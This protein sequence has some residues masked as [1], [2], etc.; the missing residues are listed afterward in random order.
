M[1]ALRLAILAA[2]HVRQDRDVVISERGLRYENISVAED[3]LK[4]RASPSSVD[5]VVFLRIQKTGGTTFGEN[6][7]RQQCNK[8][9][10]ACAG[11][12]HLDYRSAISFR[13]KH[14][15]SRIVTFLRDPVERF[16]SEFA[17]LTKG[18][19]PMGQNQWDMWN[20][21]SNVT[22]ILHSEESIEQRIRGFLHLKGSATRNRQTLYLLGFDRQDCPH[23]QKNFGGHYC[24]GH[25]DQSAGATPGTQYDWDGE[26]EALSRRA[27]E[28]LAE[29]DY[30][31]TDCFVDSIAHLSQSLNWD[32]GTCGIEKLHKRNSGQKGPWRTTLSTELVSEIE[33]VNSA[34]MK[35]YNEAKKRFVQKNP[36]CLRTIQEHAAGTDNAFDV[37]DDLKEFIIN[38]MQKE[39]GPVPA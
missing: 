2:A 22:T 29:A 33:Q 39:R 28:H 8:H 34:D 32:C 12:G 19:W 7:L 27:L 31:L 20:V 30:V 14:L 6:I 23:P 5:G 25:E 37:D 38:M 17:M 3:S 1:M 21:K 15:N 11:D 35:V 24:D 18:G 13:D 10:Q 4:T 26:S 36:A 16:M 9:G